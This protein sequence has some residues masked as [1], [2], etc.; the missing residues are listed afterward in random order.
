VSFHRALIPGVSARGWSGIGRRHAPWVLAWWV[1][2]S[3]IT[4]IHPCCE[5]IASHLPHHHEHEA[6]VAVP[7]HDHSIPHDVPDRRDHRHCNA[8]PADRALDELRAMVWQDGSRDSGDVPA[9]GA[10]STVA[11]ELALALATWFHLPA[12]SLDIYLRFLRLLI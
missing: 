5:A 3:L 10:E 12:S 8:V 6:S 7:A 2:F 1:V 11:P 4:A 9:M